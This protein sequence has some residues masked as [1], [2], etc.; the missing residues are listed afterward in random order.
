MLQHVDEAKDDGEE[1]QEAR[2]ARHDHE[3]A[4]G[5]GVRVGALRTGKRIAR[6]WARARGGMVRLSGG[7]LGVPSSAQVPI[8]LIH[9][10]KKGAQRFTQ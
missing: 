10:D 3:P 7:R 6:A 8:R 2:A 5:E 9:T 1:H 4:R